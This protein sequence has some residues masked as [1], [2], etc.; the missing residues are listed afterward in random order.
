MIRSPFLVNVAD[1]ARPMAAPRTLTVAVSVDWAVDLA[2]VLPDPPL[3]ATLQLAP[4]SGG[5]VV[6][7][8]AEVTAEFTCHRCLDRIRSDLTVKI[9]QLYASAKIADD[10]EYELDGDEID[11]EPMLRDEVL[12]AMP[13]LPVC[14]DDCP[15]PPVGQ[16]ESGGDEAVGSPFSVL[17]EL[18]EDEGAG[19]DAGL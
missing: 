3:R 18:F 13:L 5:L 14:G 15:G 19:P 16:E 6:T 17:K 1:L 2:R 4:T 8:A 7:G 12:L 10:T 11:L 9:A